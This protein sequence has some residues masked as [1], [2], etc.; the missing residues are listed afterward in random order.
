MLNLKKLFVFVAAA[1]IFLAVA[2]APANVVKLK[3]NKADGIYTKGENIEVSITCLNGRTPVAAPPANV[4][5]LNQDRTQQVKYFDKAPEKFIFA[6]DRSPYAYQIT[7]ELLSADK[8]PLFTGKGKRKK[9]IG[10]SIGAIVDPHK[11]TTGFAEPDDFQQ[12]WDNAKAELAKVPLKVLERKEMK[13]DNSMLETAPN[14]FAFRI[15]AEMPQPKELVGKFKSWDVKVACV[16][17][18]P[19]SGYLT[20][21]ANAKPP[22]LGCTLFRHVLCVF[23]FRLRGHASLLCV[24][25]VRYRGVL[26]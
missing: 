10:A 6:A 26:F 2:A 23:S 12:F 22:L 16:D 19:V 20:M 15:V 17:N 14:Y 18:V 9:A 1:G 3:L 7:V 11:Y 13:L 21:P 8:K 25:G 4:I 5:I 24:S